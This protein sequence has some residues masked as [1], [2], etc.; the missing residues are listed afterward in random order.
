MELVRFTNPNGVTT[1]WWRGIC[2]N[3]VY[4]YDS[5]LNNE[6][7]A[8]IKFKRDLAFANIFNNIS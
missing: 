3:S 8:E 1:E 4:F 7:Q 2:D 5:K 6:F